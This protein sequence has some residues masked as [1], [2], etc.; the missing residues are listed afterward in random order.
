MR[1]IRASVADIPR[2]MECAREFTHTLAAE[3]NEAHYQRVWEGILERDAGVIFLLE[4]DAGQIA[5][6]LGGVKSQCFLSGQCMAV[7][8]FW[9]CKEEHRRGT[10]P[11]RLLREFERWA[12]QSGCEFCHMIHMEGSMPEHLKSLYARLGY[13][14]LETTH[15]KRLPPAGGYDTLKSQ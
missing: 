10:W 14:L 6:G 9:Y 1:L 8:L 3:L 5:G 2:I 15:R 7:E 11:I 4:T 12:A 13:T